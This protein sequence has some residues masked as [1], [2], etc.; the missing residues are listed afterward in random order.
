MTDDI[1]ALEIRVIEL[2]KQDHRGC[3]PEVCGGSRL[4]PCAL[5]NAID[6]L[7]YACPECNA[8]GHTCPG[9]G[10]PIPHGATDC[11]EHS[12][13]P[14][15]KIDEDAQYLA[16]L[17]LEVGDEWL[18]YVEWRDGQQAKIEHWIDNVT[19]VIYADSLE[20]IG[21]F[22]VTAS[23]RR[24]PPPGP[25][26]DDALRDDPIWVPRTWTDVRSGDDVRLPGT[27]NYAHVQRAVHQAWQVDPRT[28]TSSYNPPR[29]L[30]WSGVKVTLYSTAEDGTRG[31]ATQVSEFTMDPVKPIEIKLT[32]S[33]VEAIELL[34]WDNRLELIVEGEAKQ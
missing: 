12:E 16:E 1:R 10:E 28:G 2:A 34:G 15:P 26:D 17:F 25:E 11:G 3:A 21:E 31:F 18:K 29:A 8:G 13:P 24:L 7:T 23:A 9:D 20:L 19:R 4:D 22:E 6:A 32:R 14:A 33:E 30:A 5:R 27:D